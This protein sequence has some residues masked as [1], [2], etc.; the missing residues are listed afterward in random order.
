MKV[1]ENEGVDK[2][3]HCGEE[4]EGSEHTCFRGEVCRLQ[5]Q[6]ERVG[7]RPACTLLG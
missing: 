2:S 7:L 5:A 6:G 4:E 1:L 3:H